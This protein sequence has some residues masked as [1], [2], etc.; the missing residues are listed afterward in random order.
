MHWLLLQKGWQEMTKTSIHRL[1]Q[2]YRDNKVLE[3]QVEITGAKAKLLINRCKDALK[4]MQKEFPDEDGTIENLGK[5]IQEMED[6]LAKYGHIR[7]IDYNLDARIQI[8]MVIREYNLFN[9]Q[10]GWLLIWD[11]IKVKHS[12]HWV[13]FLEPVCK[14]KGKVDREEPTWSMMRDSCCKKC[15]KYVLGVIKKEYDKENDDQ[16]DMSGSAYGLSYEVTNGKVKEVIRQ[17]EWRK[18]K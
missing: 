12:N 13:E 5:H 7:S 9:K 2:I 10:D 15:I 14:A 17:R 3:G 4:I 1:V 11:E 6:S 18:K 16:P 8:H